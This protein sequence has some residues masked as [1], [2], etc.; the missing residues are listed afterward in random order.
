[1]E[2]I[3]LLAILQLLS[4]NPSVPFHTSCENIVAYEKATGHFLTYLEEESNIISKDDETKVLRAYNC[5][6]SHWSIR[7]AEGSFEKEASEKEYLKLFEKVSEKYGKPERKYTPKINQL[8]PYGSFA[9]WNI[10][11]KDMAELSVTRAFFKLEK[12][13]KWSIELSIRFNKQAQCG[14]L[15]EQIPCANK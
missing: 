14:G 3:S 13:N 10:N 6:P 12:T 11:K 15:F 5:N 9:H 7:I 2:T 1:M 4:G 8:R